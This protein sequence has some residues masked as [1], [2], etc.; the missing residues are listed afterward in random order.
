[1]ARNI[2]IEGLLLPSPDLTRSEQQNPS[3]NASPPDLVPHPSDS[4]LLLPAL[5]LSLGIQC[6][7]HSWELHLILHLTLAYKACL[8]DELVTEE[9][10]RK[11]D[12]GQV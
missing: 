3:L 2:Y 7:R 4:C 11:E 9:E 12:D 1:M 10:R 8:G 6:V 5:H